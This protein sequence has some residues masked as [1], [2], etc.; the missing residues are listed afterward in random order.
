MIITQVDLTTVETGIP[1]L[2]AGV[3]KVRFADFIVKPNKAGDGDNLNIKL[4]IEESTTDEAGKPV[5]IGFPVFDTV[6]L[7]RTE[8]YTPDRKLAEI[9]EA[10]LGAKK[11]G[12]ETEDL[13]GKEVVIQLTMEESDQYGKQNRIKRYMALKH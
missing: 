8:K 11:V 2:K 6:A 12:F 1:V 10:A 5:A 4:T 9:Q 7:K 13:I 3:Y